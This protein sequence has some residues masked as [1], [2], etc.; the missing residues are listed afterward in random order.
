M[1]LLKKKQKFSF[2]FNSFIYRSLWTLQQI[3]I[4][5][6]YYIVGFTDGEGSFNISFRKRQDFLIGWKISP[7]FNISQKEELPLTFIKKHLNCGTIRSRHDGVFVYEVSN[8]T[9]L[10]NN[11][12][13][14]FETYHSISAW[15]K[16]SFENWKKIIFMLDKYQHLF[17]KSE[18]EQLINLRNH[19]HSNLPKRIFSDQVILERYD[20]FWELNSEKILTKRKLLN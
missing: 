11:I 1:F 2:I 7:V 13:P 10:L 5:H 12:I 4:Q 20:S 19:A 9:S 8:K 3:P 17:L 15:K 16:T 14:F 6:A 18:L